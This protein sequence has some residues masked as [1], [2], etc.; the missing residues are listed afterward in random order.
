MEELLKH[1]QE[2]FEK[3]KKEFMENDTFDVDQIMKDL[4]LTNNVEVVQQKKKKKKKSK[5]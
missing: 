5:K 1:A 2:E 4:E 3:K